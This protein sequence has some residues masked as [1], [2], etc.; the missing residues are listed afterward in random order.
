VIRAA[1]QDPGQV[2]EASSQGSVSFLPRSLRS[3]VSQIFGHTQWSVR[4]SQYQKA[5]SLGTYADISE[6]IKDSSSWSTVQKVEKFIL[7][8]SGKIVLDDVSDT[9]DVSEDSKSFVY[10]LI[11]KVL[12]YL[13]FNLTA[14]EL[15]EKKLEQGLRRGCCFGSSM[16]VL[17]ALEGS[18]EVEQAVN[19]VKK[20]PKE[21]IVLF[22]LLQ[23][24]RAELLIIQQYRNGY[25]QD[26][27][28]IPDDEYSKML[29]SEV[30]DRD[31]LKARYDEGN[32]LSAEI[33]QA[34]EDLA[35]LSFEKTVEFSAQ[36]DN[37]REDIKSYLE[38]N[39]DKRFLVSIFSDDSEVV[40]HAVVLDLENNGFFD[41]EAGY[42]QYP[43]SETC[44]RAFFERIDSVYPEY[45]NGTWEFTPVAK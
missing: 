23:D 30:E 22:Q 45:Q 21:E 2:R 14:E 38:A 19:I 5:P 27:T 1:G 31:L 17:K 11:E 29:A 43:D 24:L 37:M 15:F 40:G 34:I 36:R 20:L 9:Q 32:Q 13:G 10:E 25:L 39:S 28:G 6:G 35:E 4:Y 8:T 16:S 12:K 3:L 18:E 26:Q 33:D 42:Y 44:L 41:N 7:K